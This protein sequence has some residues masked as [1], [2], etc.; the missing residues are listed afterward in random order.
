[1][2]V[3]IEHETR[4]EILKQMA[5][6]LDR[7][8][9]RLISEVLRLKR[10]ILELKKLPADKIQGELAILEQQLQAAAD[11]AEA[12]ATKSS[13]TD[14]GESKSTKK[15]EKKKHPGHGPTAQ[16]KLEV[17]EEV[18][19]LDEADQVCGSCGGRL[20]LWEGQQDE[21]E[22]VDVVERRFVMTKRIRL[23]YRCKCGCMEMADLP[24][25]LVPGGR[26]SNAFAVEVAAM[27][28]VDQLPFDR[29][30]RI[31][32]RESLDVESQTLW[33][34]VDALGRRLQPAWSR[35][36]ECALKEPVIG[37]DQT[38]W[39]VIGHT[40]HWQMWEL[41]IARI[42]Y[43]TI[44]E[45]KGARDGE[46]IL[47]GYKGTVLCDAFSTHGALEDLLG[48]TL[49][50]CWAHPRRMAEE[51]LTTNKARATTLIGFIR[52]LYDVEDEAKGDLEL[53]REL[54]RTRSRKVLERL[55][56]WR[57]EQR[58]LPSSPMGKLLAYLENHK[59]GFHRFLDDPR[60][61]IDNNLT[62][63]GYLW[64]AI[65]R[66][67]FIGSRSK[68]GTEVAAIFYSLAESARR[69]ALDAK[70]YLKIA[71]EAALRGTEI[72][73]PHEVVAP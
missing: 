41:S 52:E 55:W 42:A 21:T 29:I 19:A 38:H 49:A 26:Y 63:R 36:R 23:K 60:I 34:Q 57:G 50:H 48:L 61:G 7:E 45:S 39:K 72:P 2:A 4:P 1:L 12:A 54:R 25:R 53:L 44:A 27:K 33:D 66:R 64:P 62:E 24:P 70:A 3:K 6:V 32:G 58:V 43:F 15:K 5:V 47:K 18:H 65:G 31:F 35:L 59:D 8:N 13:P 22:E 73:L 68:R 9:A 17:R 46:A 69:N 56:T 67:A 30:A 20:D 10:E 40:K 14:E 11:A 28:Y 51:A 37:L 16:P 71:L